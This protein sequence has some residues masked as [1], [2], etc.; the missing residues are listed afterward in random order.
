MAIRLPV[1]ASVIALLSGCAI[2]MAYADGPGEQAQ[3]CQQLHVC[4]VKGQGDL[5]YLVTFD[6]DANPVYVNIMNGTC[7]PESN[8]EELGPVICRGIPTTQSGHP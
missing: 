8:D 3:T 6:D 1:V 4:Q 2:G 5:D 7:G